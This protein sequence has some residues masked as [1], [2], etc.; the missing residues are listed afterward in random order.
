MNARRALLFLL[1]LSTQLTA[2]MPNQDRGDVNIVGFNAET[3]TFQVQITNNNWTKLPYRFYAGVEYEGTPVFATYEQ[4]KDQYGNLRFKEW[5]R[6][7]DPIKDASGTLQRKESRIIEVHIPDSVLKHQGQHLLRVILDMGYDGEP[8]DYVVLQVGNTYSPFRIKC[9]SDKAIAI[10]V[11]ENELSG[12]YGAIYVD[13]ATKTPVNTMK[14][15]SGDQFE[16]VY[17]KGVRLVSIDINGMFDLG[18]QIDFH[19]ANR[20][21]CTPGRDVVILQRDFPGAAK[22]H[23]MY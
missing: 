14:M 1:I 9:L 8:T 20:A 17:S 5:L 11:S 23:L 12:G 18:A 21:Y 2:C 6:N 22:P 7:F 16:Y 10:K 15:E 19:G 4:L 3:R 13:N